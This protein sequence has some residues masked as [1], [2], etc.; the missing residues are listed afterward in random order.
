MSY[1]RQIAK[2]LQ[3]DLNAL[4][5]PHRLELPGSRVKRVLKQTNAAQVRNGF[6]KHFWVQRVNVTTDPDR[7]EYVTRIGVK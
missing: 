6:T 1:T 2:L 5:S 4:E 3:R 7:R